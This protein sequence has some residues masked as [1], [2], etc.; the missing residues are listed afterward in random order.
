MAGFCSNILAIRRFQHKTSFNFEIAERSGLV[1][2]SF[3]AIHN[4]SLPINA[5][6]QQVCKFILLGLTVISNHRRISP[7]IFDDEWAD[8]WLLLFVHLYLYTLM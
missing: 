8:N 6:T 4:D 5:L 3:C 7:I 2:F 1:I